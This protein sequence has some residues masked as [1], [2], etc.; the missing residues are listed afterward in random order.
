MIQ[1]MAGYMLP[2]TYALNRA[3]ETRCDWILLLD[4]DTKL[5]INYFFSVSKIMVDKL[6]NSDVVAIVSKVFSINGKMISPCKLYIGRIRRAI[7]S[8]Y[9]GICNFKISAIN[10]GAFINCLLYTSPSP[11]D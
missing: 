6:L 10:S 9:T 3:I 8:G 2:Y 7:K 11:R 5:P 4:Q 1:A